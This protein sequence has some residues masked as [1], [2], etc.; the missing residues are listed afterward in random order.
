[1]RALRATK[2]HRQARRHPAKAAK[3]FLA[4]KAYDSSKEDKVKRR[5]TKIQNLQTSK[6]QEHIEFS[7]MPTLNYSP[8][9]ED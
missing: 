7:D 4:L 8:L 6:R 3:I 2:S 1:M 5:L 9:L